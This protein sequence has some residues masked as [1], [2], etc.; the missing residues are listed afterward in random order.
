[1]LRVEKESVSVWEWVCGV[2][3][4]RTGAEGRPAAHRMDK[5]STVLRAGLYLCENL[6]RS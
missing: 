5:W 4:L 6:V 1:M 3:V 2:T